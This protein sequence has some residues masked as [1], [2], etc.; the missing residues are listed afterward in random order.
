[1]VKQLSRLS[2]DLIIQFLKPLFV[3]VVVLPINT[4]TKTM[5]PKVSIFA[6]SEIGR[7]HV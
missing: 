5:V 1:M 3:L 7:A 6:K 2:T 4:Y